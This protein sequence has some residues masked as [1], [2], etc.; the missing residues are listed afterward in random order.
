MQTPGRYESANKRS[1]DNVS[2]HLMAP[3]AALMPADHLPPIHY[4]PTTPTNVHGLWGHSD[5]D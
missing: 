1:A 4:Q 3:T 5:L 2:L